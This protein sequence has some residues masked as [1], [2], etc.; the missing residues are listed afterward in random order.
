MRSNTQRRPRGTM[1]TWG[2]RRRLWLFAL[3]PLLA[4]AWPAYNAYAAQAPVGL[5]TA[6]S[7]A[8]LAG[9]TVTNTGPSTLN[10][11]LGLSPGTAITGFPPGNVNGTTHVADAVAVQA[12]SD[13]TTAYNDA[14]G[15]TPVVT[16]TS[17]LGGQT[18]APGVYNS[19]S[20]LGLTGTLTLDA[21]GNPNAVF[22]FQA[23]STL[24][25][26]SASAVNL[27]NGAQACNV[28]WQVGSSATLGA[29]SVF[30]GNILADTSVS[31]NDNVTVFGRALARN[32]AVTL[33][34]DT[35]TPSACATAGGTT[36][37]STTGTSSTGAPVT[38]TG[39]GKAKRTHAGT[40]LLATIP[41]AVGNGIARHGTS[42]RVRQ[43][44]R[45]AVTGRHIRL[46]VFS[47][48]RRVIAR[49]HRG[50]FRASVG[51]VGGIRLITA[52]VS[53]MDATHAKL[54]HIRYRACAA[55]KLKGSPPAQPITV[56]GFTG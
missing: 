44:F 10:G 32:G 47:L 1:S 48:G 20:S 45:V 46:V 5:G 51:A 2:G 41:R 26:A 11:D 27:I 13:L 34:D 7:F 53:F 42:R 36:S 25:T 56:V 37:T 6:S 38:G 55:A 49:E 22:I 19:A 14:A 9:S 24:T 33:I 50:P 8:V 12:Q 16:V 52:R 35:I 23:G 28:Y 17:D 3:L 39:G 4:L 40:A 15:R 31:L 21:Q 18:L 43:A 30:V 29:S 54:L